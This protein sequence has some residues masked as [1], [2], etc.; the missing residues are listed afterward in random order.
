MNLL[1][2][3]AAVSITGLIALFVTIFNLGWKGI[4]GRTLVGITAFGGATVFA[5]V[6]SL[7]WLLLRIIGDRQPSRVDP[8]F[9][10]ASQLALAEQQRVLLTDPGIS[11]PSVTENTTRSF[12]QFAARERNTQ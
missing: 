6:G 9:R 12:D 1:L 11:V 2:P 8:K 3:V 10:A 7:I 4:D 5:V